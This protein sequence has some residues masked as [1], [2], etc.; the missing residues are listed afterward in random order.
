MDDVVLAFAQKCRKCG[1]EIFPGPSWV[2]KDGSRYYCS[3]KC[4]N[5]R[6][7]GIPKKKILIPNIG[8]TIKI[9]YVSGIPVLWGKE[10]VV[11]HIDSMGQLHG[12]WGRLVIIPGEDKYVIVEEKK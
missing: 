10:G 12:T 11:K 5:H 9:L 3:W 7:D 4:Y 2:Y 8:D 6:K 1:K